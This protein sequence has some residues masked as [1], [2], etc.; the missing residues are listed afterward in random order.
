MEVEGCK[1]K[2]ECVA[3]TLTKAGKS[4]RVWT[5]NVRVG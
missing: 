2:A 5:V 4:Y 1:A 3:L